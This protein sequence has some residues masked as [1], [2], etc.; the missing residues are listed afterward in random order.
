MPRHF[1][2][3]FYYST[4]VGFEPIIK[5]MQAATSF[6]KVR[7]SHVQEPVLFAPKTAGRSSLA[8]TCGKERQIFMVISLCM[9]LISKTSGFRSVG[10]V[11][12]PARYKPCSAAWSYCHEA[13]RDEAQPGEENSHDVIKASN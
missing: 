7:I 9:V 10:R 8:I 12:R 1:E 3:L 13:L 4:D 6:S 5:N 2:M 11:L